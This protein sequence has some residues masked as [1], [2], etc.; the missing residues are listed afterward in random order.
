MSKLEETTPA[1]PTE[2][3]RELTAGERF[4]RD[5]LALG[6]RPKVRKAV[7]KALR[8]EVSPRTFEAVK[9]NPGDLK[10]IAKDRYGNAVVERP[11]RPR[12]GPISES[13]VGTA[14]YERIRQESMG[15][16]RPGPVAGTLPALSYG[17]APDQ[18]WVERRLWNGE[19]RFVL[20]DVRSNPNVRHVYDVFDVLREDD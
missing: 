17:S 8:I 12:T 14:E 16:P 18:R 13:D 4:M 9:A 5:A 11:H 20:D 6:P 15:R 1:A 3:E 2:P 10:L 7:R 19:T